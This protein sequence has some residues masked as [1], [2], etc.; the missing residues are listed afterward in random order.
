MDAKRRSVFHSGVIDL[1]IET[2]NLPNGLTIELPV[3]R[4]PGAA[5]VVALDDRGRVAM[6][7]QFR[8]AVGGRIWEIPA[9]GRDKGESAHACAKRELREEAGLIAERWERLGELVTIPSF[10]DE[11]IELFLARQLKETTT[12]HE[13]DEVIAL[14]W[15]GLEQALQMIRDGA[16]VDA[17]T[18]AGLH[19]TQAFLLAGGD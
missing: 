11:R 6:I 1:G 10:C 3:I 18:I 17:K 13:P 5:A 8:H 12:A 14:Q 15:I 19:H 2:A 9:G 16:I 4:H 7:H